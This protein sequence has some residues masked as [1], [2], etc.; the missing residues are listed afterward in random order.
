M[1]LQLLRKLRTIP[2]STRP[3]TESV[4]ISVP[5]RSGFLN[6]CLAGL[7]LV[8][9]ACG[10]AADEKAGPVRTGS[11]PLRASSGIRT[12][13]AAVPPVPDAFPGLTPRPFSVPGEDPLPTSPADQLLPP[14]LPDDVP[15]FHR[16]AGADTR[17]VSASVSA[18]DAD[19]GEDLIPGTAPAHAAAARRQLAL[20]T[21]ASHSRIPRSDS[22]Y[23]ARMNSVLKGGIGGSA[24]GSIGD[25]WQARTSGLLAGLGE[26]SS[27]PSHSGSGAQA[28]S[29]RQRLSEGT[30]RLAERITLPDDPEPEIDFFDA[31]PISV[32]AAGFERVSGAF[33]DTDRRNGDPS[34]GARLKTD[35]RSI[36][37]TLSYALKNIDPEQLPE[38]FDMKL[39][40]EDYQ[41]RQSSATVFQWA[42]TNFYH[43]PLYFEDPSL[44]RYG[45]TY[46]PIIQPFASTGRFATQ[47]VG[48]PYQMALHPVNA[49]EYP[50]G[51]YRPGEYAPKQHPQIPFNEEATLMQVIAVAG[52]ILI[53]P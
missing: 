12:V 36:Q 2:L 8:S 17:R 40:T 51:R 38:E 23:A 20:E 41:P 16:P 50:L 52:L 15:D 30:A 33:Q 34:P 13:P 9:F 21:D 43:Y 35:I 49:K 48:L 5:G 24:A 22:G 3:R 10:V 39:N 4:R 44:E 29:G 28:S 27:S 46:H 18:V 25:W 32:S 1:I 6:S 47:L 42:P 11:G 26:K 31:A 45:H 14:G 37:P 7:T 53:I 19:A